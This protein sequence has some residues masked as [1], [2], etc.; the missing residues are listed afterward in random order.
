ME[1]DKNP[2]VDEKIR[3][4]AGETGQFFISLCTLVSL[5]KFMFTAEKRQTQVLQNTQGAIL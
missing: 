2:K 4:V 1:H 3:H 5:L